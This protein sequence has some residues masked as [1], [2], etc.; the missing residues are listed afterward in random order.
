MRRRFRRV[1]LAVGAVGVV[2]IAGAVT[3]V[4]WP[5]SLAAG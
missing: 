2:A 4:R 3:Y 1:A 5:T